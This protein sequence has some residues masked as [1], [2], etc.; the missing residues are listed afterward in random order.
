MAN[1]GRSFLGPAGIMCRYIPVWHNNKLPTVFFCVESPNNKHVFICLNLLKQLGGSFN[2]IDDPERGLTANSI[3]LTST[4]SHLLLY[5]RLIQEVFCKSWVYQL[6]LDNA[7][8]SQISTG[9]IDL[10]DGRKVKCQV[11]I[12]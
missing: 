5:G 12:N 9:R 7:V 11:D 6:G 4:S 3:V 2:Q 10:E 1:G 8:R